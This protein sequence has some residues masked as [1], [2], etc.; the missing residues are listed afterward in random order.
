MRPVLAY[1]VIC[2]THGSWLPNDPRGSKSRTV[3]AP[4]LQPFGEATYTE[5]RRSVAHA[6][7]DAAARRAAKQA[8]VYPEVFLSE[9]QI[10]S[11]SAGFGKQVKTSRYVIHACSIM[12]QHVHL[13]IRRHHYE[14]EQVVRLL[15][16]AATAQLVADGL[17]PFVR[18]P[19]GKLPSIW[20][21][22]SWPR[23]L[24]TDDDIRQA[25]KYVE[26]N[27]CKEGRPPQSWPWI[28]PFV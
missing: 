13:V 20:A 9:A 19:D 12:S 17:H 25:I 5:S 15:R 28:V 10:L 4:N 2:G 27:P 6:R 14:V 8:L 16:Q 23:F 22:D 3:W 7:H 21:Q 1:H 24:F 11:V 18:S 26:E